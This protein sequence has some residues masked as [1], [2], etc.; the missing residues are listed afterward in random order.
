V[1]VALPD[2]ASESNLLGQFPDQRQ[3]QRDDT[4]FTTLGTPDAER[5]S[6]Q[7]DVFDAQ[8]ERFAHAQATTIEHSHDEIGGV[9]SLVADGLEKRLGLGNCWCV[10]LVNRTVGSKGL[11]VAEG[12]LQHVLVKKQDCVKSL[13]LGTGGDI[14]LAGQVGE[15]F[16]QFLLAGELA[17]HLAQRP[18]VAAEPQDVSDFRGQS[19][20]LSADNLAHSVDC[21]GCIHIWVSSLGEPLGQILSKDR[22]NEGHRT[23]SL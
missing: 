18:D 14:A 17:G 4:I 6:F 10:T 7:V 21:I 22:E 23:L 3:G 2:Y 15:E 19:L 11:H 1:F 8:I 16:F 9:W 13:I 20:M 5:S 12:L